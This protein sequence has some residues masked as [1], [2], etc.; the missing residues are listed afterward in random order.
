M[1]HIGFDGMK[2]IHE[3]G[4]VIFVIIGIIHLTLNWRIFTKYFQSKKAMLGI[5][6]G[7]V[8]LLVTM[9]ISPQGKDGGGYK[10]NGGYSGSAGIQHNGGGQR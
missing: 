1:F 9:L 4:G 7:V 6:T 5:V 10:R 2:S 8:I 3:W